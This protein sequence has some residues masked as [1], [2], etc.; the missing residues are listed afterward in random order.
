MQVSDG[1]K[2]LEVKVLESA[3]IQTGLGLPLI[4]YIERV[5][6]SQD[7]LYLSFLH[8]LVD[9]EKLLICMHIFPVIGD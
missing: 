6:K 4:S 2:K 3:D 7:T 1:E 9:L 8:C 5:F